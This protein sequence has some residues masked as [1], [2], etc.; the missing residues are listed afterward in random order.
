MNSNLSSTESR[1]KIF[2][3]VLVRFS[4]GFIFIGVVIFVPAG[5]LKFFNGWLYIAGMMIPMIFTLTYLL[6][7]DPELLSKRAKMKE[8]ESAQK[9]YIV[10]SILLF[11]TAFI[12]PGLDFRFKWSN[13]PLWLVITSLI[14]MLGGYI[15]FVT[16]MLQNRFASR[17][18]EIQ[19]EQKLIDTGLYSVV[20]HP[21]YMAATILYLASPLVL[22]SY[23]ALIPILLLPFLLAFRIKNE[24]QV[25]L[26]GLPGYEEYTKKVKYRLIPYIW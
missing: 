5:T 20:R 14:I 10:L 4:I 24:E 2:L 23:Y 3:K 1:K 15:M 16:V 6:I 22:G 7:R 11:I 19:N 8:K 12:I 25:L 9:I 17:V 13:I 18:I 21:M 26:K